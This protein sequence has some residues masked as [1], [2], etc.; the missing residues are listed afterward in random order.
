M[1]IAIRSVRIGI[2]SLVNNLLVAHGGVKNERGWDVNLSERKRIRFFSDQY[3]DELAWRDGVD[4]FL[5]RQFSL[6]IFNLGA[7]R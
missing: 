2:V 1:P 4:L 5:V 3:F 6:S 7:S